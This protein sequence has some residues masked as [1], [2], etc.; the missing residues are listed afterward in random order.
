MKKIVTCE[1]SELLLQ[2]D[3]TQ[4]MEEAVF[5]FPGDV[6]VGPGRWRLNGGRAGACAEGIDRAARGRSSALPAARVAARPATYVLVHLHFFR[7]T[8]Y[9]SLSLSLFSFQCFP[10]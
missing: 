3:V 1:L 5:V 2:R 10:V 9:S 8:S 7:A 6:S 4:F